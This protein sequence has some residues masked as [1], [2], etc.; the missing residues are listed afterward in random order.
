MT[1]TLHSEEF[2]LIALA[3][4]GTVRTITQ[5]WS[6]AVKGKNGRWS[7]L[8]DPQFFQP[9]K[10]TIEAFGVMIRDGQRDARPGHGIA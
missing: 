7:A 1:G 6:F 2:G 5:P 10:N 8:L 3:L 4:N 9:G